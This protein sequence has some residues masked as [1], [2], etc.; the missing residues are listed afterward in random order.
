M[1]KFLLLAVMSV[2]FVGCGITS[3]YVYTLPQIKPSTT[4]ELQKDVDLPF[5]EAWNK[6][7]GRLS[8]DLFVV[9]NIDKNS[10]FINADFSINAPSNY[11]DCGRWDGMFKNLS[12]DEKYHFQLGAND[13]KYAYQDKYSGVVFWGQVTTQLGGKINILLEKTS[14]SS[15][16]ITVNIRYVLT[17]ISTTQDNFGRYYNENQ[18]VTFSSKDI[19]LISNGGQTRCI[20]KGILERQIL[21]YL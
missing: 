18:N 9:N 1:K 10:G 13:R 20:S 19:G 16:K 11:I 17:M 12:I 14:K 15:S 8:Q 4:S 21:D 7:V 6:I 3:T 5:D 2:F